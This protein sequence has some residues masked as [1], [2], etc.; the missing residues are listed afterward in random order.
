MAENLKKELE[1]LRRQRNDFYIL[2]QNKGYEIMDLKRRIC[3][4]LCNYPAYTLLEMLISLQKTTIP[5]EETT[6]GDHRPD[7]GDQKPDRGDPA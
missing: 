6:G 2:L 4:E 3:D 7:D 5:P 1:E